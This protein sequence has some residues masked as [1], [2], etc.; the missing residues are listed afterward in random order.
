MGPY[1]AAHL[2]RSKVACVGIGRGDASNAHP[3]PLDD[4]RV[5]DVDIR[6]RARLRTLIA[7]IRPDLVF[8][9]AAISHV[10]TTRQKPE[11]AFDVNVTGTFNLLES[12]R[13]LDRAARIVFV[14]SGNLYGNV[15]SG[16]SGFSEQQPVHLTS[17]YATSKFIG[18]HLVQ[19]YV[20]DFSMEIV[21]ARPF[22][23]T[24]PGQSPS[25]ACPQFARSIAAGVVSG[26]PVHM[27]TGNLDTLRDLSDVRDVVHAYAM[28]AELGKPGEIYNV[29]SGAM[30]SMAE[31]VSI[32]A[33]L[34]GVK[35][36]TECDP[37]RVRQREIM[38]LGGNCSKLKHELGWVPA[39][40]LR[41]TMQDLL[42][43]WVA[44]ESRPSSDRSSG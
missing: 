23:H 13:A 34:G 25:F 10:P 5:C 9:L 20:H 39:I 12:M 8:H 2:R 21:I 27:K 36:S 16:D 26:R 38:R 33:E 37:N 35:V 15:D 7:E 30:V 14:S 40:S 22:N 31:V 17:P 28:L 1:L 42:N 6:D 11:L 3:I 18:E 32:L 44:R 29:C 41:R 24:G 4:V 43:Y 19:C